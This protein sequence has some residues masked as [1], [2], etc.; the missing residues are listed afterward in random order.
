MGTGSVDIEADCVMRAAQAVLGGLETRLAPGCLFCVES[1]GRF[2]IRH[3]EPRVRDRLVQVV[4]TAASPDGWR[5]SRTVVVG[6][7]PPDLA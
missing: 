2:S 1:A 5:P 3:G 7:A 6:R 4:P